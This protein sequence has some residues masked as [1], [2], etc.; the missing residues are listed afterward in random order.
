MARVMADRRS[1]AWAPPT[2][3]G[4]YVDPYYLDPYPLASDAVLVPARISA[5]A[6]SL[7]LS[8]FPIDKQDVSRESALSPRA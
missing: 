8:A 2:S 5:M 7:C 3:Y 6:S 4:C 1:F